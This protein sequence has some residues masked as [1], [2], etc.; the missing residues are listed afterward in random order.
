[1]CDSVF[2]HT[3]LGPPPGTGV[4]GVAASGCVCSAIGPGEAFGLNR[5]KKVFFA[6]DGDASAVAAAGDGEAL[7]AFFRATLNGDSINPRAVAVGEAV[8]AGEDSAAAVFRRDFLAGEADASALPAAGLAFGEAAGLASAFLCDLC[9]PGDGDGVGDWALS[10]LAT[11][12]ANAK[13]KTEYLLFMP[14]R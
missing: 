5:S 1:M 4:V 13:S 7:V 14:E 10:I 11:A 9:L 8:A 6:G 12:K 3:I 2:T